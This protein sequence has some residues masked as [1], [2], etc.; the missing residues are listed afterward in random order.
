MTLNGA[1]PDGGA[2]SNAEQAKALFFAGL[3][4]FDAGDYAAAEARFR[5][6]LALVPGR[7]SVLAN[8]A[9]AVLRQG[10]PEEALTL[11]ERALAEDADN[12]SALA[13]V[14]T[15]AHALGRFEAA[16]AA[17]DR[18]V[19]LS[20]D[21]AEIW[22]ERGD[23]LAALARWDAALASYDRALALSPD[24]PAVLA[25][26]GN[27][28][29]QVE[30]P[31]EALASYDRALAIAPDFVDALANRGL[32]LQ[33]LH[34]PE[35]ALADYDR[36]LALQPDHA[37]ALAN[38]GLALHR[39]QHTE[40][41]LASL[42]RALAVRP[43][44]PEAL[45]GRGVV[46]Q[47]MKR[48]EEALPDFAR[49][50]ELRPDYVEAWHNRGLA[51]R[52][53]ERLEEAL[54]SFE[55]ALAL[56]PDHR[57]ALS[58]AAECVLYLDDW[59]RLPRFAH[60]IEEHV[61]EGK[62]VVTPFV[63]LGYSGDP[64][65]QLRCA[66]TYVADLFPVPLPAVQSGKIWRNER[67]RVAYLSA[68]FRDHPV[69]QL[70]AELYELHDRDRFEV[71]GLS[72]GDD[73]GSAM[74]ARVAAAFDRF[75][76]VRTE[77]D[78]ALAARLAEMRV[79][80]AVDLTGYTDGGRPGIFARRPA[81]IQV[82]YLGFSAT[83]G[84]PFIDYVVGDPVLL[85]PGEEAHYAEKIVRLP[86]SYMASDSK[87]AIAPATPSRAEA[88]LPERGFV[89]SS[90]NNLWKIA[91]P[92]FDVWMRLL[93]AVPESVLWLSQAGP[94]PAGNLRRAAEARGID[95][96]RLV[97]APRLPR[98]ADHLARQ[99]L[100][101]LFLDT[102]PY[103]AHTTSYDALWAGLPVLTCPG[104]AFSGR[105]AASL[106]DAV[107]LPEMVTATLADYE[108]LALALARDPARL[109]EI[110]AKLAGN[111]ETAPLFDSRRFTRH[112][113]SAY[114]AMW[115]RWQRGEAPESFAVAP[116]GR[117]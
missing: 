36:A 70:T 106:L 13:I 58:S 75:L 46:L 12:A 96:G 32:T 37:D 6:A 1:G 38:R 7:G 30:R 102:L 91:P 90:F 80:I 47:E 8:L 11:A 112:L 107:G 40:A 54:A 31:D 25:N 89:F 93:A 114:T 17:F 39:L 101:D 9:G 77:P 2:M 23:V 49:A 33:D 104:E 85:P 67:I 84:S 65:L 110:R 5:A 20:A 78:A 72:L 26:R 29:K 24:Q 28:L 34:R 50:L 116:L 76:D 81:P 87:R 14:A 56:Q 109:A 86:D 3:D 41:A 94:V 115:E 66:E 82:S 79:D 71:I 105:V 68:D 35:D 95:P 83:T 16:L 69:S 15:A 21:G 43:D 27:V 18:L 74:R 4:S 97:F 100:A 44:Y 51:L 22:A 73:D 48:A 98:L 62:S 19:A 57:Y 108:A 45:N 60:A 52:K 10:R 113:E 92:V 111:R 99:R 117:P 61:R 55:R 103:N 88:G 63:L 59:E 42:D 53:L 64:A